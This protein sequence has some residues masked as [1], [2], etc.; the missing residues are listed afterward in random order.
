MKA[1]HAA[2]LKRAKVVG[3]VG[4]IGDAR[5]LLHQLLAE[6]MQPGEDLAGAYQTA[7]RRALVISERDRLFA[8]VD[9]DS[10]RVELAHGRPWIGGAVNWPA[11]L[12]D[13][14]AKT[15]VLVS[16]DPSAHARIAV[17]NLAIHEDLP[18]LS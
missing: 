17:D 18:A 3:G 14:Q 16:P 5:A 7:M 13:L 2:V 8:A 9:E 11:P 4:D 1:A 15:R 10:C 6:T 12:F